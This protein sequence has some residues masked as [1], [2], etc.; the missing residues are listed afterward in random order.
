MSPRLQAGALRIS[1]LAFF[2]PM[3]F[4]PTIVFGQSTKA[5]ATAPS[6]TTPAAATHPTGSVSERGSAYYHYTLSR[7]YGE[8]AASKARQDYATQAIEEYKLALDADPDSRMLQD[9]LP[10]LY[11]ML[12]RIREA[13]ASAQDQIAKHP[14]DAH[15]HQLLGRVYLRSLGDMQGP[16]SGEMLQLALKEYEIIAR[17]QPDDLETRLLL[18][19]L[20]GLNHDSAKAE[21]EFKEAQRIDGTSEE[22]V[23]NMARLYTEQGQMQR[24]ADT[25]TAVPVD[26]RSARM[27]FALAGIYDTLKKPKDAAAA[28]Q[29]SLDLDPD[30]ADAKRGLANALIVDGK[31]HAAGKVYNELVQTDPQDAQSLI[32]AADIQRREGHYEEALATLKKAEAIV[33]DNPELSFN[34]ALTYDALGRYDDAINTLKTVLTTT[35]HADGKYNPSELSNRGIFLDRLAIIYRE[36]GKTA[37]SVAAYKELSQLG[38]DYVQRGVEGEVDTLRDAHQWPAAAAAAAAAAKTMPKSCEVQLMYARQL[39]DSGKL[40]DAIK[41]AEKQLNGT[42]EDRDVF[43]TVA[44]IEVRASRWKEAAAQ[45]D[46]AEVLAT[47]PDDKIFL[48]YYRGTIANKQKMYDQAEIEFRKVLAIDPDN[49]AAKNDLGYMLADRGVKLPEAVDLLHKAVEFDPQNGSYLDSLGWA[50]FKSGQYALAEDNLRNA[51]ARTGGN[52]PTVLDHLGEVYEKTGK[53]KLAIQ[54][55]QRSLAQYATSLPADAEPADVAHVER[56]LESARVKLAHVNANPT[57]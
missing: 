12:G 29:R 39:A 52:D 54:Q 37:E 10:D 19:Q 14:E 21:A 28:Y 26:D 30:N 42:P 20:Y 24:A 7:M 33:T 31:I 44:D 49:A 4:A 1:A 13:V 55:W 22:V 35:E 40:D 2:V 17:L 38:P 47:K 6:A 23:L 5:K 50:Y 11:F 56:K 41:L 51:V 18:G 48:H 25:L 8:M 15:A 46:K 16:Q 27:E 34:E 9:G 53:L 43:Y 3:F 45:L 32:R 57:K 36:Q